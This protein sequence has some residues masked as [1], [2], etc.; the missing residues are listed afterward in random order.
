METIFCCNFCNKTEVEVT[1]IEMDSNSLE[2][3]G[4]EIFEFNDLILELLSLK[5]SKRYVCN[6]T[7]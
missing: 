7:T 6:N 5:V 1:L 2:V 3:D 4:K